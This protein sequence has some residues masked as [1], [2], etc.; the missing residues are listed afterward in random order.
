MVSANLRSCRVVRTYQ[1]YVQA[2][3]EAHLGKGN[4]A[5]GD[6]LCSPVAHELD[7]LVRVRVRA[8]V[9]V[10]ARARA[11]V[12]GGSGVVGVRRGVTGLGRG[13]AS[14]PSP[15]RSP[16]SSRP[17]RAPAPPARRYPG[18]PAHTRPLRIIGPG[19]RARSGLAATHAKAD[20]HTGF[21]SGLGSGSGFRFGVRA[22]HRQRRRR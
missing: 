2:L 17:P 11:R 9:R 13:G 16:C 22:S 12:G 4:P 20:R 15:P 21:G 19:R 5:L 14:V 6:S 10:M 7:E 1:R 3:T 8:R 18:T